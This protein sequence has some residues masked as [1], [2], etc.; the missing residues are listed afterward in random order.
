MQKNALYKMD[1]KTGTPITTVGQFM[2][3]KLV[4]PPPNFGRT[5]PFLRGCGMRFLNSVFFNMQMSPA[6]ATTSVSHALVNLNYHC[7]P[8]VHITWQM[9]PAPATTSVSHSPSTSSTHRLFTLTYVE[10]TRIFL[11]CKKVL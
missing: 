9:S 1:S 10:Q 4:P 5:S 2:S 7:T 3:F 11:S 6:P 8:S